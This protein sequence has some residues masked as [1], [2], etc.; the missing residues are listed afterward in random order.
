MKSK[1]DFLELNAKHVHALKSLPFSIVRDDFPECVRV[2]RLISPKITMA[3]L[4]LG[5]KLF[6]EILRPV[7]LEMV[8]FRNYVS[9]LPTVSGSS[10][11]LDEFKTARAESLTSNEATEKVIN[12]FKL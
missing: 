11:Y 2:W 6:Y 5:K 7:R 9:Y 3:L 8:R 10:T 4:I 12:T 1:C